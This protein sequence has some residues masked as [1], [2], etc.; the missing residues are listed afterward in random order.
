[1]VPGITIFNSDTIVEEA[2][3]NPIGLKKILKRGNMR[4]DT[5]NRNDKLLIALSFRGIIGLLAML[6]LMFLCA[7]RMSYWQ[8]WLFSGV[9]IIV[10]VTLV[11][12]FMKS[13][14]ADLIKERAKP[15]PGTK[16][17]D[18]VFLVFYGLSYFSI[19]LIGSLDS[20]RYNWTSAFPIYLY[21]IGYTVFILSIAVFSWSMWVNRFFSSTVRIQADRGQFVIQ[22][23]PYRFIR[24]PGYV[25]GILL[26]ISN[27]I[28]LGSVWA[29]IPAGFMAL[30][31]IIRTGLEDATLQKELRGYV[32]YTR[33]TQ[34][35]LFPG[36]W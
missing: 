15:G 11:P 17:W 13:N 1:M 29:L 28:V 5:K 21:I 24:H 27:A 7:G 8:G 12:K 14:K 33:K 9:I 2:V 36:L 20:G 25:A 6:A 26:G 23:G 18:K 22:N 19:I 32:E 34:Y 16:S 4:T 35:R 10:A 30:S 3:H 31:L